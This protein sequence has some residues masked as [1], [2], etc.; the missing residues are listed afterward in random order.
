MKYRQL[1]TF[2]AAVVLSAACT[3]CASVNPPDVSDPLTILTIGTADSGGTMYPVGCAI[4]RVLNSDQLKINVS[5]SSGSLMNIENLLSGE[6]DL[7]LV[8]GD[9]ADEAVSSEDGSADHLRAI[10]AVYC[11]TS[12]WIA[13]ISTGITYVHDLAGMRIGMGPKGSITEISARTVVE[14]LGLDQM[15]TELENCSLEGGAEMVLSGEMAAIHGF[16]GV[17]SAGLIELTD[18]IPCRPLEYT[19][20]ELDAILARNSLY[21]RTAIP[22]GTYAGQLHSIPTFG[23]KCLLCVDDSMDEELVYT[24]TRTLWDSMDVLAESHP[25]LASMT[26]DGFLW[27]GLPIPLHDGAARFYEENCPDYSAAG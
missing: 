13:P 21:F 1:S 9:A 24:L 22:A 26:Q 18:Q 27:E 8:S 10:A 12:N 16:V 3:G 14:T 17:P 2:L 20:E 25:A 5:A 6:I 15:G 4:A 23:V 7:G 11:S 19:P